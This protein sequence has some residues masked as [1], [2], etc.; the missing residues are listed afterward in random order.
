MFAMASPL[1]RRRT[2]ILEYPVLLGAT[3][4]AFYVPQISSFHTAGQLGGEDVSLYFA[5]VIGCLLAATI[6]WTR[7]AS[8]SQSKRQFDVAPTWK[9]HALIICYFLVGLYG[10]Y[11]LRSLPPELL[12]LGMWSGEPVFF[13][14]FANF[15][16]Y[17]MCAAVP[18]GVRHRQS[19]LI[20]VGI[21]AFVLIAEPVIYGA[22]RE[23]ATL[24]VLCLIWWATLLWRIRLPRFVGATLVIIGSLGVVTIG[25]IRD[26]LNSQA[27]WVSEERLSFSEIAERVTQIQWSDVIMRD[28]PIDETELINALTIIAKAKSIEDFGWGL[29]WYNTLIAHYVPGQIVGQQAKNEW[30]SDVGDITRVFQG[31]IPWSGSTYT[32]VADAFFNLVIFA[33]LAYLMVGYL[34][35]GVYGVARSGNLLAIMLYP[36]LATKGL[37]AFTHSV[38]N[39]VAELV[40]I[41]ILYIPIRAVSRTLGVSEVGPRFQDEV[42]VKVS[43]RKRPG[44]LRKFRAEKAAW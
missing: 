41:C 19:L 23:R 36:I 4:L 27:A 15:L 17:A 31:H 20:V 21:I 30:M 26:A 13:S 42:V 6:G 1:L 10:W 43:G 35:G 16:V 37:N 12:L 5:L 7:G 34:V 39:F 29:G 25:T 2:G 40:M 32:G 11:K 9:V 44:S 38:G 18:S 33:P 8:R 14:F 3:A 28:I 24:L 22:R